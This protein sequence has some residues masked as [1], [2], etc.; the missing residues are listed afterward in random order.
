MNRAP[1]TAHGP[2]V[3]TAER[4]ETETAPSVRK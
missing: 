1:G 2:G 3:R 4:P